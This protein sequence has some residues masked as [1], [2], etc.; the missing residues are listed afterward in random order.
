ML[1]LLNSCIQHNLRVNEYNCTFLKKN[2]A[3]P[4]RYC[5]MMSLKEY[6]EK[7]RG[8][9]FISNLSIIGLVCWIRIC[10]SIS[11]TVI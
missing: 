11:L 6:L 7:I 9:P 5:L 2:F 3:F 1:Q 8:F 10:V 4:L